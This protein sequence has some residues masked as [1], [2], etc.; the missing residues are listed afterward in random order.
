LN[1][2]SISEPQYNTGKGQIAVSAKQVGE[3]FVILHKV[4]K[5]FSA[6]KGSKIVG[7]DVIAYAENKEGFDIIQK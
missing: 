2:F 5:S 1:N 4:L 6:F 7:P 3:D